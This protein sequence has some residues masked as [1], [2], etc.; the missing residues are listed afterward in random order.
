VSD[1]DRDLAAALH[2]VSNGLTV[3]LGWLEEAADLAGDSAPVREAV[4]I[5]QQR[6]RRAQRIA[7]RAIGADSSRASAEP[8]GA[9]VDEC[10]SGLRPE[11][12]KR[13]LIVSVTA[14]PELRDVTVDAGDKLLQV[15]TNLLLN[16]LQATPDGGRVELL[17]AQGKDA[18]A[19][20][21]RVADG[22]PGI[23][24]SERVTLFQRGHSGRAG[25]A[26]I[27]L[28]HA[29]SVASEEGGRLAVD[30]FLPGAGA[31][32]ELTWPTFTTSSRQ[33]P[34]TLRAALLAGCRIAIVDDDPGVIDLLDMVFTARGASCGTFAKHGDF[35]AALRASP[36]DVA[37]LDAS[38]FGD[39]LENTLRTLKQAHPALDLILISGSSDPGVSMGRLGV[40]WIRKPFEVQEVIDVVRAVRARTPSDT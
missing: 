2:E 27:G 25:G 19:V 39:E 7:R 20:Q 31:V 29:Q 37:L 34:H 9:I 13:L 26:G 5:A 32:F 14:T 30:A 18:D 40:T 28:A 8:L 36:F 3:I 33:G 23:V 22:G 11:A 6:A 17:V 10:V 12:A 4:D 15:L 35:L 1:S 16:A 38:P 21:V 24:D